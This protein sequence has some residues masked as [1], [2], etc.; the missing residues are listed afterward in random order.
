[1]DANAI[2][3][4]M[5]FDRLTCYDD[6]EG[7][8]EAEPYLWTIFFK[9]D[10]FCIHQDPN[11]IFRLVGQPE[12]FFGS[13]SHS[14]LLSMATYGSPTSASIPAGVGHWTTKLHNLTIKGLGTKTYQIP[15]IIGCIG[16]LMEEDSLSD[17]DAEAGHQALNTYVQQKF[18]EF[19]TS[20][21][22]LTIKVDI[23]K[24]AASE[25]ISFDEAAEK[26]LATKFDSMR[27]EIAAS[28]RDVV[29][30]AVKAE[31][32]IF[33]KVAAKADPDDF[34]GIAV[35]TAT[36]KDILSSHEKDEYSYDSS[37]M[38]M[39]YSM[40]FNSRFKVEGD[41]ALSASVVGKRCFRRIPNNIVP[42]QSELEVTSVDTK[43]SNAGVPYITQLGGL[44]DGK[45]WLLPQTWVKDL[46]EKN[47]KSFYVV[48]KNDGGKTALKV[49]YSKEKRH[50]YVATV[51]NE[52][53]DD[54]LL[55]LP[56]CTYYE[57]F[58]DSITNY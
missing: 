46:I 39:I 12:F 7:G 16:V 50:S 23:D 53:K 9:L 19:V 56:G 33:Q 57:E 31:L 5:G 35:L 10:D 26:V 20:L 3:V 13:G 55:S 8:G 17:A 24:L 21:N 40:S 29:S 34:V 30:D 6:G 44:A 18:G 51:P 49:Y 42:P 47:Q 15:G 4:T 37:G 32:G 54:N 28:A 45:P 1:M 2:L 27:A 52:T 25:K 58:T 43:L 48:R 41:W 38:N 22:L 36:T 11:N 14:N